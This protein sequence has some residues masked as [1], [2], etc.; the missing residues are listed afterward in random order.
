MPFANNVKLK[1]STIQKYLGKKMT[2]NTNTIN[3]I[4]KKNQNFPLDLVVSICFFKFR[5]KLGS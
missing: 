2:I 3:E 4:K 5:A 1:G